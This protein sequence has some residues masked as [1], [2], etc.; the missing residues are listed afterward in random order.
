MIPGSS[1]LSLPHGSALGE[2]ALLAD[3]RDS[4]VICLTKNCIDLIVFSYKKLNL[5]GDFKPSCCGS[6]V[7]ALKNIKASHIYL[8]GNEGL[9]LNQKNFRHVR[10]VDDGLECI[11]E[12]TNQE[13]FAFLKGSNVNNLSLRALSTLNLK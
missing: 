13:N 11:P 10:G 2:I 3:A 1:L 7:P 9:K 5:V 12:L 4:K 8:I 6:Y